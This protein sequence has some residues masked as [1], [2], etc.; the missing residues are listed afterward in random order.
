MGTLSYHEFVKDAEC[1]VE[2]SVDMETKFKLAR[3]ADGKSYLS[4]KAC[5]RTKSY[6]CS[7]KEGDGFCEA[8][9]SGI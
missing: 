3:H 1:L 9:N 4:L 5:L 7:V 8:L 2:K 6:D